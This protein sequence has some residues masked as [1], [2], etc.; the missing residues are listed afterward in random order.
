[1]IVADDRNDATHV[2]W[3][4]PSQYDAMT[5]G[6]PYLPLMGKSAAVQALVTELVSQPDLAAFLEESRASN[7][8]LAMLVAFMRAV[9]IVHQTHHWQ[10]R[11][12]SYYGDH[13]LFERL[14]NDSLEMID[15][16]AERAVGIH[17]F[18][19]VDACTMIDNMQRFVRYICNPRA[20]TPTGYADTSLRAELNLLTL[21]QMAHE[22]ID[23][24]RLLTMGLENLLEDIADK[25]EAFVYL[26]TQRTQRQLQASTRPR[27]PWKSWAR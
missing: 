22:S 20:E 15:G 6:P 14:Y 27:D 1:M 8:E 23:Y 21:L 3:Q 26:L 10:T 12:A 18:E 16:L 2:I 7:G 24:R 9:S 4:E 17:G 13:L 19:V 11:G 25:H 5:H